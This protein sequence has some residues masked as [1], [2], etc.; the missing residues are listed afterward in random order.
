[1]ESVCT[2]LMDDTDPVLMGLERE[3]E[4]KENEKEGEEMRET[5][6]PRE[7]DKEQESKTEWE[8][9][10]KGLNLRSLEKAKGRSEE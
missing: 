10:I 6:K 7:R 1:M 5:D 2:R 9:A 4:S 3:R 8:S